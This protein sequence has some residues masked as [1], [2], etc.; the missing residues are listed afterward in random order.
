MDTAA[1][2]RRTFWPRRS[3]VG[4]GVTALSKLAADARATNGGAEAEKYGPE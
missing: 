1:H 3:T 4:V 2:V